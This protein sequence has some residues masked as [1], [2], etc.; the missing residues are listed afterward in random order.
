MS[1]LLKLAGGIASS[2][3]LNHR[4]KSRLASSLEDHEVVL[5]QV[6]VVMLNSV[7]SIPRAYLSITTQA[8]RFEKTKTV[9]GRASYGSIVIRL[10]DIE[11][12]T[13]E[14]QGLFGRKVVVTAS[15]RR[16]AFG[17]SDPE[18]IKELILRARRG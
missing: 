18:E 11:S 7:W 14:K 6:S 3:I 15:G 8:L 9:D 4:A 5:R 1:L 10:R 17:V 2:L 12:V 16:E 13:V